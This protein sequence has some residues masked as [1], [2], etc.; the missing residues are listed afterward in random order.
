MNVARWA[1]LLLCVLGSSSA[2]AE[3]RLFLAGGE[4]SEAAYYTYLGMIVPGSSRKDGRGFFQRYWIDG[5]GYEYDAAQG[6]VEARAYG[7][8]ASLGWGTSSRSGWGSASLGLRFTDTSLSPDDPTAT[9]RDSQVGLKL[10]FEGEHDF[11]SDWRLG[12]IA[13]YTTQQDGYWARLR[14]MNRASPGHSIGVEFVA[15]GNDE[16]DATAAGLMFVVQ[17]PGGRWSVGLKAGYRFQDDADG[18]YG[19]V[20]FGRSF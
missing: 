12:G 14:L 4:Y 2:Q 8:E 13:S 16:A 20:E 9:A 10:Q 1:A 6:R 18:V 19:G 7:G 11:G 5:F 3:D 17:P 15:S